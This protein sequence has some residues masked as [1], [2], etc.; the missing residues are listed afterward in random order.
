MYSWS[1]LFVA[2]IKIFPAEV[3]LIIMKAE[4]L[5]WTST[6]ISVLAHPTVSV[7]NATVDSN[8]EEML[9]EDRR[10]ESLVVSLLIAL[11][12]IHGVIMVANI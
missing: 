2:V 7:A 3:V 4:G 11:A 9:E 10:L 5:Y 8:L 6:P 12:V 1:P